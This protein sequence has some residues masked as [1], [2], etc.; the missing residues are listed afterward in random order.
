MAPDLIPTSMSKNRDPKVLVEE[1]RKLLIEEG[2]GLRP[3]RKGG[4]RI[5]SEELKLGR[6][7]VPL[8]H[9]YGYV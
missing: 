8:I 3:A 4:V 6:D 5:E 7:T 1:L 2:S 9:H